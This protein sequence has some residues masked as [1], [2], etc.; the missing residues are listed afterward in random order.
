MK[1]TVVFL[2]VLTFGL[3]CITTG[4][5][6]K[7]TPGAKKQL[8]E[9]RTYHFASAEKQAAFETFLKDAAIPAWNRAGIKP[10]GVFKRLAARSTRSLAQFSAPSCQPSRRGRDRVKKGEVTTNTAPSTTPRRR[11]TVASRMA[12]THDQAAPYQEFPHLETTPSPI[13]ARKGGK[14]IARGSGENPTHT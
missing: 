3:G 12:R 5:I 14:A 8:L 4:P 6:D 10:V 7:S 2:F 9:L 1:N 11:A 13:T